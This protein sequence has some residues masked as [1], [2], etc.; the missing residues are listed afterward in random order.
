MSWRVWNGSPSNIPH[1]FLQSI[2]R[3][4]MNQRSLKSSILSFKQF[5]RA[6]HF[7][8]FTDSIEPRWGYISIIF[9]RI[10]LYLEFTTL[11]YIN[12]TQNFIWHLKNHTMHVWGVGIV[13]QSFLNLRYGNKVIGIE[14]YPKCPSTRHLNSRTEVNFYS[15]H[16]WDKNIR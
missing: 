7:F 5:S 14:A 11:W 12:F 10:K 13:L 6:S 2:L 9:I 16:I 15:I 1:I 3:M 8:C 4:N